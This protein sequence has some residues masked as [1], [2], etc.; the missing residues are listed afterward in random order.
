MCVCVRVKIFVV[1]ALKAYTDNCNIVYYVRCTTYSVRR[2]VNVET[3]LCSYCYS[4]RGIVNIEHC[5]AIVTSQLVNSDDDHVNSN[6]RV[7]KKELDGR[8]VSERVVILL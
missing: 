3:L 8:W 7:V 5:I 1:A 2:I 4:V 6:I